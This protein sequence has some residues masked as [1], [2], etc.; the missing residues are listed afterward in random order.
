MF[1]MDRLNEDYK[2]AFGIF[3]MIDERSNVLRGECIDDRRLELTNR[4]TYS[5][6][7]EMRIQHSVRES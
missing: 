7:V 2:N 5:V 1:D 4:K 6:D 3:D